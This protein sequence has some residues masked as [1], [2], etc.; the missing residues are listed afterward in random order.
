VAVYATGGRT[1]LAEYAKRSGGDLLRLTQ[2]LKLSE[3]RRLPDIVL[4]LVLFL[5]LG[6]DWLF[7]TPNAKVP[8]RAMRYAAVGALVQLGIILAIGGRSFLDMP[9]GA[10]IIWLVRG[11]LARGF[12]GMSRLRAWL[13]GKQ[14]QAETS[15]IEAPLAA[16]DVRSGD[17]RSGRP[18]SRGPVPGQALE[19]A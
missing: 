14:Y 17:E 1:A 3:P 19:R 8:A 5:L 11:W 13:D 16:Y 15:T 12:P 9:V 7:L 6:G 4:A 10:L 2:Q 18:G